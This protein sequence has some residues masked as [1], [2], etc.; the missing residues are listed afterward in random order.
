VSRLDKETSVD[1]SHYFSVE[2]KLHFSM[3]MRSFLKT[4]NGPL[5]FRQFNG[6]L[7]VFF[8]QN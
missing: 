2:K 6:I 4:Q 7:S 5:K 8:R 3:H 1:Q